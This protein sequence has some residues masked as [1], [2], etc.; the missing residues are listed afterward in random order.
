MTVSVICANGSVQCGA[1]VECYENK[2]T[3]AK[4]KR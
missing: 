4:A 2:V 3:E 1:V